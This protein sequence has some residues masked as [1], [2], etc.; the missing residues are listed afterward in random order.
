MSNPSIFFFI[1]DHVVYDDAM[2]YLGE[3]LKE[4]DI[5]FYANRN[6]WKE[7]TDTRDFL[8]NY[9]P[10]IDWRKCDVVVLSSHII[11]NSMNLP[12]QISKMQTN[13]RTN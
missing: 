12:S 3:G 9:N 11:I 5:T 6:Y 10:K 13:F 4:L 2:V 1:A 8:F 7:D